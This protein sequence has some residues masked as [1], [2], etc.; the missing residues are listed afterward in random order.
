[1]PQSMNV[2]NGV[3]ESAIGVGYMVGPAMGG[4]LFELGGGARLP[5]L[6]NVA[7]VGALIPL[8]G[9]A[10]RRFIDDADAGG[11][12]GTAAAA[13]AGGNNAELM[14]EAAASEQP[15]MGGSGGG[16]GAGSGGGEGGGG[17]GGGAGGGGGGGGGAGGG[18]PE[19]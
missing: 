14:E 16:G 3:L 7:V 10:V 1:M 6:A 15:G 2:A 19:R 4:W 9:V 8:V 17:G 11:K 13:A 18:R 5:L 12:G